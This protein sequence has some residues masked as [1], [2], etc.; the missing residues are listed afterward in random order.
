MLRV[1]I[2][3]NLYKADTTGANK[4]PALYQDVHFIEIFS[5]IA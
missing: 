4:V 5:K 1:H 2:Q 3:W